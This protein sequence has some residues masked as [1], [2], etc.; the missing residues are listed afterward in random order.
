MKILIGIDPGVNT[1]FAVSK[2]GNLI[3]VASMTI[4]KAMK[5]ITH[6]LMY[7]PEKIKIYIEDARK[8]RW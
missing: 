1:G 2:N 8:R 7:N 3:K 5:E 4:N 6:I